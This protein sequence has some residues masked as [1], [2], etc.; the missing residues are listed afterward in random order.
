MHIIPT[1]PPPYSTLVGYSGPLWSPQLWDHR[2]SITVS[3]RHS[4]CW[5]YPSILLFILLG[6]GCFQ[7]WIRIRPPTKLSALWCPFPLSLCSPTPTFPLFHHVV[8]SILERFWECQRS[9]SK[10]RSGRNMAHIPTTYKWQ[11]HNFSLRRPQNEN[12][13]SHANQYLLN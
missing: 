13:Q 3:I 10:R 11:H 6:L 1:P 12:S 2:R 8:V 9:F 7:P 4:I 5:Q